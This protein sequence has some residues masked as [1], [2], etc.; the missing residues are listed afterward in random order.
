MS[1]QRIVSPKLPEAL[2]PEL[3]VLR[4]KEKLKKEKKEK[5]GHD[6]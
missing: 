6:Y 4:R 5:Q 1:C 2:L 3:S